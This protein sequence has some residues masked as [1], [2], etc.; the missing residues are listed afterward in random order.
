MYG[1]LLRIKK[2]DAL[3]ESDENVKIFCVGE[4]DWTLT[5]RCRDKFPLEA[6]APGGKSAGVKRK[7]IDNAK[8]EN[9]FVTSRGSSY[10]SF[11]FRRDTDR[12]ARLFPQ[13]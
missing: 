1:E 3:P 9:C 7:P 11:R 12:S 8:N 4:I 10:I 13:P 6:T 5:G 2:A